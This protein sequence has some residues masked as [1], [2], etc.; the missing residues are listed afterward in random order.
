L[1]VLRLESRGK[2]PHPSRT[3]AWAALSGSR[4][5]L[6]L[7]DAPPDGVIAELRTIYKYDL[8]EKRTH[9]LCWTNLEG[10][11]GWS[12]FR[13]LRMACSTRIASEAV[14][15]QFGQIGHIRGPRQRLQT[16]GMM[17]VGLAKTAVDRK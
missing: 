4:F 11:D 12:V 16:M 17:A 6:V 3:N 9:V 15:F 1:R 10:V 13:S 2:R 14:S 8:L 7:S 5:N